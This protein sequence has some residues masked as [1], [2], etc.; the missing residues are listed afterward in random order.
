MLTD[1]KKAFEQSKQLWKLLSLPEPE[2]QARPETL[3][4]LLVLMTRESAR[5][6]VHLS[7]YVV[8]GFSK[9]PR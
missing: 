5:K 3:E 8:N 1:P 6:M 7:N 4:Q 2:N 9:I